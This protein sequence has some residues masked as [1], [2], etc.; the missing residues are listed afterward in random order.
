MDTLQGVSKEEDA[1]ELLQS[2]FLQQFQHRKSINFFVDK[3]I[4]QMREARGNLD[5]KEIC[6]KN[7]I[8]SRHLRRLF[9]REVGLSPRTFRRLIR[10]SHVVQY[11]H[12]TDR[13]LIQLAYELGYCDNA[14]LSND[15][16]QVASI[17][18]RNYLGRNNILFKNYQQ[19]AASTSIG[20]G[21]KRLN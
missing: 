8:T 12:Q 9:N 2:F 18:P 3:V 19:R 6:S 13:Q 4:H 15:F 7:R 21:S 16:K 10:I 17:S 20:N 14:H 11:L 5:L 1:I